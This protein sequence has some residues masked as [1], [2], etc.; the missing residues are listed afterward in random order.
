MVGERHTDGIWVH[1]CLSVARLPLIGAS[2]RVYNKEYRWNAV[3]HS[4]MATKGL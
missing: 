4:G 1:P 2:E 3:P